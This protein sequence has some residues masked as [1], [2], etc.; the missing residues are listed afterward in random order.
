MPVSGIENTVIILFMLYAVVRGNFRYI[1]DSPFAL[2]SLYFSFSLF[3][4]IGMITPVLGALVRYKALALPFMV[5]FFIIIAKD[6]IPVLKRITDRLM[7]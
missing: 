2:F 6:R 5:T 7:T 4:L 3:T 1:K